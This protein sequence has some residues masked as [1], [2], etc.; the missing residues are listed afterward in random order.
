MFFL[1]NV[2]TLECIA[3]PVAA[4]VSWAMMQQRR[5]GKKERPRGR[6]SISARP[7]MFRLYLQRHCVVSYWSI[8]A[9]SILARSVDY[10]SLS[11][12]IDTHKSLRGFVPLI[13]V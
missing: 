4:L 13:F 12:Y 1:G 3:M 8:R 7:A 9:H 5:Y 6:G 10:E 11:L 2:P